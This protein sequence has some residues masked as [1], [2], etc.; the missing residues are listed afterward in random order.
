MCALVFAGIDR[1][2]LL[3]NIQLKSAGLELCQ[4]VALLNHIA[5]LDIDQFHRIAQRGIDLAACL[6]LHNA[7]E[8]DGVFQAHLL[9]G[10]GG[11]GHLAA[12]DSAVEHIDTCNDCRQRNTA[13][14]DYLTF[15]CHTQVS[16]SGLL[17]YYRV[18][19]TI[20]PTIK[21]VKHSHTLFSI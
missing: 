1:R 2:L 15:L 4:H 14:C 3:G 11:N 21:K 8:A 9:Q 20:I 13:A 10:F 12:V 19:A 18:N 5:H 16:F 7:G 6:A 17:L